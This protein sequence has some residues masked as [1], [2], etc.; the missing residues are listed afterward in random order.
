M[1][2]QSTGD[3]MASYLGVCQLCTLVD[4]G[5]GQKYSKTCVRLL[6]TSLYAHICIGRIIDYAKL[7][8]IFFSKFV[9]IHMFLGIGLRQNRANDR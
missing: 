9:H 2:S 5:G 6:S 3:N 4:R 1:E 8:K 7:Y